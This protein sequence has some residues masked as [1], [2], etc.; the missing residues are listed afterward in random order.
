MP[1]HNTPFVVPEFQFPNLT[2]GGQQNYPNDTWQ[3][4]TRCGVDM[5]AHAGKH[6]TKF[7]GE[8]LRVRDTKE[9]DLNRR[10]TYTFNTPAVD[11]RFW[12]P[13]SR[14]RLERS[15]ALGHQP[16]AAVPPAVHGQLPP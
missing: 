1:F 13:H 16:A 8:F 9:W 10:G 6:E 15:D 11:A 7:G 12:K 3:N 14:G 2:L 4:S 5:N